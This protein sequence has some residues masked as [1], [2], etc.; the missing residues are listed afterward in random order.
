MIQGATVH[1]SITT[2]DEAKDTAAI[3]SVPLQSVALSYDPQRAVY[4]LY[5]EALNALAEH[6]A[7]KSKKQKTPV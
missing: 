1:L 2:G 3:A 7:K 5:I 6:I 4:A